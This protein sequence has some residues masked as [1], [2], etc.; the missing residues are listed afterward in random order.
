[1][2]QAMALDPVG[3]S[4]GRAAL[5][6]VQQAAGEGRP[7]EVLYVDWRMPGM[8]GLETARQVKALDLGSAPLVVM[9]TAH[10]REEIAG[11]A[12]AIGVKDILL[13]P[14]CPSA[15]LD[16]TMDAMS[17]R[18]AMT[19]RGDAPPRAVQTPAPEMATLQEIR[20]ARVLLVEDNDINQI[21]A[22][23]ILM[24]MGLVVDFA[25]DGLVALDMVQSQAY[26]I[27]LMDMQ[28]PV[29]DGTTA[30]VEIRK[31][32]FDSLPI[33]AMTAN[34]MEQDRKRCLDAGMNDYV[35]K[36]IEP[37][38][39]RRVLLKWTLRHAAATHGQAD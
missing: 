13:K 1:M 31:L 7:F 3:V 33:V 30:T 21:V 2:L 28:M 6:A 20:G 17:A 37:A 24:D 23:E 15:L 26:D 32:G 12:Q 16:A 18:S 39:L 29:M 8:D 25:Q 4:S 36:P 35:S 9:V 11:E 5:A 10:G 22:S 27:V 19:A 14:V 38:E 34:A